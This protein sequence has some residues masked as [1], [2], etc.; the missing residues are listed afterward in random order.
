M[1]NHQHCPGLSRGRLKIRDCVDPRVSEQVVAL[2]GEPV[3]DA[4]RDACLGLPYALIW[5]TEKGASD[6]DAAPRCHRAAGQA[7][8]LAASRLGATNR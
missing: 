4:F 8:A 7:G 3:R 1:R 6:D 2:L 5:E